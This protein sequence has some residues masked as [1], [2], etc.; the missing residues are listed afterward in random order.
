MLVEEPEQGAKME[1]MYEDERGRGEKWTAI[2]IPLPFI[3]VLEGDEVPYAGKG[4][5]GDV[6]RE[7]DPAERVMRS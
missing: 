7:S 4:Q 6:P 2:A 3:Q 1:D 5:E